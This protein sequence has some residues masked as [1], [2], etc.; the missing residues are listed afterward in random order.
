M[1]KLV[2][3]K[4]VN[5]CN[6]LS[7]ALEFTAVKGLNCGYYWSFLV[8]KFQIIINLLL[9]YW[10]LPMGSTLFEHWRMQL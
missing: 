1:D 7:A 6:Y 10:C 5:G 9:I 4:G 3:I 2:L 8:A